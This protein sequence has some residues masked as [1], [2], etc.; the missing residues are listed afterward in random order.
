MRKRALNQVII[1][2]NIVKS[3]FIT[4]NGYFMLDFS[5]VRLQALYEGNPNVAT[6]TERIA[7]YNKNDV[8]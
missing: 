1:E 3:C 4:D 7:Q 8:V 5:S 6:I 2:R